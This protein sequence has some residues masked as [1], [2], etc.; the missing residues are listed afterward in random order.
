MTKN[1]GL[2]Q[3]VPCA[4]LADLH[5]VH[6]ELVDLGLHLGQFASRL[7]P[8]AVL[9]ES[10]A[11][12]VRDMGE[13][14]TAAHGALFIGRLTVELRRPQEVGMCVAHIGRGRLT[15]K[16]GGQRRSPRERVVDQRPD[17]FHPKHITPQRRAAQ[18]PNGRRGPGT[19]G[20]RADPRRPAY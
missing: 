7:D 4:V 20:S 11:V 18:P 5:H 1:V 9:A 8:P 2:D 14:F 17:G 12:G 10:I 13:L 19:F 6:R 16:K 15:A 3:V